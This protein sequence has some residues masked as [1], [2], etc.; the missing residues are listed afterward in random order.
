M[1]DDYLFGGGS[2]AGDAS[3]D[4]FD[5][6]DLGFTSIEDREAIA[7]AAAAESAALTYH[8]ILNMAIMP[9]EPYADA[10][11]KQSPRAGAWTC[12]GIRDGVPGEH[13]A[14][15]MLMVGDTHKLHNSDALKLL[16]KLLSQMEIS[17]QQ[18]AFQVSIM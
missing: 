4:G 7:A 16:L 8:A 3:D 14:K 6:Y 12:T 13:L 11:A 10:G 18:L 2:A 15:V 1:A 17:A 9:V 5:M